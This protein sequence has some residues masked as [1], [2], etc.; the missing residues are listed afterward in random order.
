M[1]EDP[2]T[3]EEIINEIDHYREEIGSFGRDIVVRQRR[4]KCFDLGE[5]LPNY[6]FL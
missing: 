4:N 1:I 6:C 2:L 3:Q 5:W